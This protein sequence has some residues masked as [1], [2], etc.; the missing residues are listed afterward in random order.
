MKKTL[1]NPHAPQMPALSKAQRIQ[2]EEIREAWEESP[3]MS[4]EELRAQ[5]PRTP[6]ESPIPIPGK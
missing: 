6:I 4:L 3:E 2:A 5:T 1:E